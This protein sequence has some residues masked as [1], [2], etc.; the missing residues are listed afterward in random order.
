MFLES[1]TP[2]SNFHITR[3][4]QELLLRIANNL[5]F[6]GSQNI[7]PLALTCRNFYL[8]F[9]DDIERVNLKQLICPCTNNDLPQFDMDHDH[10]PMCRPRPLWSCIE[11]WNGLEG[12]L[13]SSGRHDYY[14]PRKS[15]LKDCYYWSSQDRLHLP[16]PIQTRWQTVIRIKNQEEAARSLCHA[17]SV[18]IFI[19][20]SALC[21]VKADFLIVRAKTSHY[22][23]TNLKIILCELD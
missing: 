11:D 18:G 7:V 21:D 8:L 23:V 19:K 1:K 6:Y 12:Y 16:W 13:Y 4:P 14:C 22:A 3:L 9:S 20:V 10:M 15:K 2:I 5:D 17:L